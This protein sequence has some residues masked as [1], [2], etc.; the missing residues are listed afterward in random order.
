[1][2]SYQR[3]QEIVQEYQAKYELINSGIP[4]VMAANSRIAVN[5]GALIDAQI[6]L[7]YDL[8]ADLIRKLNEE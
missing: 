5:A 3:V 4:E 6:D 7:N 2:L 8:A 1:M